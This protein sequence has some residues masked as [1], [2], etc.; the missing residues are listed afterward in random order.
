MVGA[1]TGQAHKRKRTAPHD[2][3]KID[4]D[5]W[6]HEA[7]QAND[8]ESVQWFTRTILHQETTTTQQ[9]KRPRILKALHDCWTTTLKRTEDLACKHLHVTT[10]AYMSATTCAHAMKHLRDLRSMY[11]SAMRAKQEYHKVVDARVRVAISITRTHQRWQHY[12]AHTQDTYH[13][14]KQDALALYM[15]DART[16]ALHTRYRQHL[17]RFQIY[18]NR[19]VG[20]TQQIYHHTLHWTQHLDMHDHAERPKYD[21]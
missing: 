7:R 4:V 16:V 5:T 3:P 12:V 10:H 20:Y 19:W 6:L 17:H 21:M 1:P 15:D 9:R 11:D 14:A 13:T 18:K 8:H 2:Q